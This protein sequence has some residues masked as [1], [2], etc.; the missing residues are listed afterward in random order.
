[1]VVLSID[2]EDFDFLGRSE[3]ERA[4]KEKAKGERSTGE[5]FHIGERSGKVWFWEMDTAPG[6]RYSPES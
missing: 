1:M 2:E 4:A 3:W 6:K 5:G